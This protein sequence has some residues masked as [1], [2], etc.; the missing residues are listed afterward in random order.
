MVY[1]IALIEDEPHIRENYADSMRQHHYDVQTFANRPDAEL[2]LASRLPDLAIIDIGLGDEMDGG[3]ALCQFLRQ[4][5]A[6]LPIIFLSARDNDFDV[7]SG[8]RMGADD[9]LTKDISLPHLLARIAAIFRRQEAMQRAVADSEVLVRGQ[10]V[11]D[12]QKMICCW[13]DEPLELTLTEFWMI[14][15]LARRPG[16][17]KS[18]QQLMLD[19]NLVVDDATVTSHIKRIRRKF[20]LIDTQFDCIDTLYGMGYRWQ[21]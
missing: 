8:L 2:A 13:Q 6:S 9:Y 19:A 5:S 4:Q 15:S 20:K 17:V 12:A 10:L 16:H 18:R 7:V 21:E 3:F 1:R 11:I 14:L